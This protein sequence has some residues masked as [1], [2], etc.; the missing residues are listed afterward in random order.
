M[1]IDGNW[2]LTM[3]SPMGAR[4]ATAAFTSSGETLGG[5]FGGDAGSVP[6]TGTVS[7][8]SVKWAATVQ[9]PMGQME[10]KFDGNVDGDALS[11][12][13]AFGAFGSGSFTGTRA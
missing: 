6:V 7:G 4:P 11:G 3:Q 2:N 10:L 13:V 1:A 5:T 8:N 9:G 12:T